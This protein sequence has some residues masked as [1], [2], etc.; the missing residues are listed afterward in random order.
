MKSIY[1]SIKFSCENVEN[2][3]LQILCMFILRAWKFSLLR[4]FWPLKVKVKLKDKFYVVIVKSNRMS[5]VFLNN[6][7]SHQIHSWKIAPQSLRRGGESISRG[8][9]TICYCWC[10]RWMYREYSSHMTSTIP[11]EQTIFCPRSRTDSFFELYLAFQ[12]FFDLSRSGKFTLIKKIFFWQ[13][14]TKL[15]RVCYVTN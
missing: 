13:I 6:S 15:L 12:T 5:S 3:A 14:K 7:F 4:Q 11:L 1:K 10:F 8:F 2:L 9:G